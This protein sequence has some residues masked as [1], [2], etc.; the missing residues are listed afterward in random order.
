MAAVMHPW[1]FQL[2]AENVTVVSTG[3]KVPS[4]EGGG[5]FTDLSNYLKPKLDGQGPI[6]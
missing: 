1:H 5:I 6:K 2:C 4:E 3:F